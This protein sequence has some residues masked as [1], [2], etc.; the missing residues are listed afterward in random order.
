MSYGLVL[1]VDYHCL[2]LYVCNV[3]WTAF[4]SRSQ[5]LSLC[6]CNVLWTAFISRSHLFSVTYMYGLVLLVDHHYLA[7]CTCNILR[8]GFI[9]RSPL[10]SLCICNVLWT[11]FHM[12]PMWKGKNP[13]ILGSFGLRSK[14][15]LL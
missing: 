9:G 5:L 12:I 1:L 13:F 7:L 14:S 8:T 10:F 3:I 2:V 11:A 6:I 4:F 15:P